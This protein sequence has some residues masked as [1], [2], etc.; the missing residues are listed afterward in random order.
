MH[1]SRVH[2][3]ADATPE[4][5]SRDLQSCDLLVQPYTDGVS[6]RRGTLMAALAHGL[7]VVTTTG[8][9]SEPFWKNSESVVATSPDDRASISRI[10]LELARQPERR[11]RLG[12]SA[13]QMYEARFSLGHV[14]DALRSDTC[15]VN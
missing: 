3:S 9:L 8:P 10:I 11:M 12:L 14:I 7:P 4:R 15:V 13:R 5:L 2:A 6:T 1:Q